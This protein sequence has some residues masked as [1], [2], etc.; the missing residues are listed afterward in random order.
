MDVLVNVHS[1]PSQSTVKSDHGGVL[2]GSQVAAPRG[3]RAPRCGRV[4]VR[5]RDPERDGVC[6]VGVELMGN[7]RPVCRRRTDRPEVLADPLV[8]RGIPRVEYAVALVAAGREPGH[9]KIRDIDR[10]ACGIRLTGLVGDGQRDRVGSL[11]AVGVNGRRAGPSTIVTKAPRM[12]QIVPQ[13]HREERRPVGRTCTTGRHCANCSPPAC[14]LM[15]AL[16]RWSALGTHPTRSVSRRRTS[17]SDSSSVRLPEM[18]PVSRLWDRY[19]CVSLDRFPSSGGIGPVNSLWSSSRCVS[20]D[21]SP[22][23]A[24][25]PPVRSFSFSSRLFSPDCAPQLSE[26]RLK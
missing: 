7:Q 2:P 4:A 5:V 23:S 22:G 11:A 17:R 14:G 6:S 26:R 10:I 24:G 13:G 19:R 20:S 9:R 3:D 16:N 1:S 8:V 12:H 15:P 18:P 25:I 21:R